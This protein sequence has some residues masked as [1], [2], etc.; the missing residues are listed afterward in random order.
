MQLSVPTRLVFLMLLSQAD[1][2]GYVYGDDESL[3][4]IFNVPIDDFIRAIDELSRPDP[5]STNRRLDG[6]RVVRMQG[7]RF[8]VVSK[9]YFGLQQPGSSQHSSSNSNK[10]VIDIEVDRTTKTNSTTSTTRR[11]TGRTTDTPSLSEQEQARFG[12]LTGNQKSAFLLFRGF[13]QAADDSGEFYISQEYVARKLKVTQQAVSKI[14]ASFVNSHILE[15]TKSY[16]VREGKAARYRWTVNE[17]PSSD[18][19]W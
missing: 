11:T 16:D 13:S 14:I 18:D 10:N 12:V 7:N 8:F 1:W 3:A 2:N 15:K 4:R 9:P 6:R 19:P 17:Q 5:C